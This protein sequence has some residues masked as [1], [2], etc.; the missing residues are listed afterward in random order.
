[1]YSYE[2]G[3]Y[4]KKDSTTLGMTLGSESGQRIVKELEDL[5]AGIQYTMDKLRL[6]IQVLKSSPTTRGLEYD[7]ELALR[8]LVTL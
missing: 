5:R 2:E 6:T 8:V 4:V 3:G 7:L 1:M